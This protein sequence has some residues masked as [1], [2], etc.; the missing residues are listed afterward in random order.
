ML[1]ETLLV[2]LL[3]AAVVQMAELFILARRVRELQPTVRV[4][5]DT[6]QVVDEADG[7]ALGRHKHKY[8]PA[9]IEADPENG[10]AVWVCRCGARSPRRMGA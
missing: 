1:V 2:A 8:P 5:K 10:V 7:A 4:E 6:R 9:L 3:L